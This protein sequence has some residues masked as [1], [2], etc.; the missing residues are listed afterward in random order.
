[1]PLQL[2]GFLC[3]AAL[4]EPGFS[5]CAV[6]VLSMEMFLLPHIHGAFHPVPRQSCESAPVRLGAS[7]GEHPPGLSPAQNHSLLQY[8][9]EAPNT[10][11]AIS[12]II[13][14]NTLLWCN[15]LF[16]FYCAYFIFH[17]TWCCVTETAVKLHCFF[18]F[19]KFEGYFCN[20]QGIGNYLGLNEYL[21]ILVCGS[22]F[23]TQ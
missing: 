8:F 1:M 11:S 16:F 5:L 19:K 4:D 12:M 14:Q 3:A 22:I 6:Q 15:S 17:H 18:V 2:L 7:L 13:H 21:W 23:R 9:H 20:C 10:E